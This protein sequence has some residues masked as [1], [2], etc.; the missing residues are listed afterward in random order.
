MESPVQRCTRIVTALEDLAGQE[1]AA[2]AHR[3]FATV[4]ALQDR[5]TP[6]VEFLITS[7]ATQMREPGLRRRVRALHELRQK[8][9]ETL[10]VAMANTRA[11]LQQTQVAQRRV[12][13]IAP[14][15]GQNAPRVSQLQA[16]G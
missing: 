13:Q 14:A 1:A 7:G 3:D 4:L 5:T 11:D 6:L 2:L 10:A 8:T 16:V 15:Y 12:A 9:S